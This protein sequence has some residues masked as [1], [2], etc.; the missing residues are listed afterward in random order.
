MLTVAEKKHKT[1]SKVK[2][3]RKTKFKNNSQCEN[4]GKIN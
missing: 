4:G 1:N 3:S 2:N